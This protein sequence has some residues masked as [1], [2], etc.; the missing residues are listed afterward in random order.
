MRIIAR[1]YAVDH[2]NK[3]HDPEFARSA[4]F[5][6]GVVP[7]VDVYAYLTRLVL[8]Q[9]GPTWLS[10]GGGE[11]R[12]VRPVCDGDELELEAR[13]EADRTLTVQARCGDEV[14]ATLLAK[15]DQPLI[16][17]QPH[18][19]PE[20]ALPDLRLK[21]HPMSF[22]P[23][24]WLGSL[25]TSI[26][27]ADAMRQLTE[28]GEPS[29][30]YQRERVIHPGHLL[31]FADSLIAA[32]VDLPPWMHVGSVVQHY[33]LVHWEDRISV[34][35]RVVQAFERKGHDF[36]QLDVVLLGENESPRLHVRPYTAIY[37]P[38]FV[39]ATLES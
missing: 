28:V 36:V 38:S 13:L 26:S 29:S 31:R 32:N 6:G 33:G 24:Q 1:N 39:T 9:W 19:F 22:S 4:G 23:G 7:G 17:S 18:Q 25:S 27:T 14:R 34:R 20:R 37:R 30:I 10:S 3:I 12:F 11:V 2:A 16:E 8:E 21:A 35:A 5:R 15:I